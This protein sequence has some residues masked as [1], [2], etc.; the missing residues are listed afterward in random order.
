MKA[1]QYVEMINECDKMTD[2][3]KAQIKILQSEIRRIAQARSNYQKKVNELVL[4]MKKSIK[5]KRNGLLPTHP[6]YEPR[7]QK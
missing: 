4:K 7:N 6:E 2:D 5:P 1:W 3:N